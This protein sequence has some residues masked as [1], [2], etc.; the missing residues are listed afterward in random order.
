[1]GRQHRRLPNQNH[2]V[3]LSG[4]HNFVDGLWPR[5]G[6]EHIII[7]STNHVDK[8]DQAFCILVEWMCISTYCSP[9][10]FKL[11]AAN[12]LSI[13]DR[14]LFEETENLIKI[15]KLK[16]AD[17]TLK[18]LIEFILLMKKGNE[19]AEAKDKSNAK[20]DEAISSDM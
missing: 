19:E 13:K 2:E 9:C 10:G 1:M 14:F 5:C 4:F 15:V 18:G 20:R 12:Y 17:S 11:L 7:F 8:L 3:T 16:L 6:D